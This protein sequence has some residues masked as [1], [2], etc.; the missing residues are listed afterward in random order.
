[1]Q[2]VLIMST[3]A[4]CDLRSEVVG[5]TCEDGDEVKPG[6][7]GNTRAARFAHS[8]ATPLHAIG[9]GWKLIG[10]PLRY[11]EELPTGSTREMMEWWFVRDDA[12][13]QVIP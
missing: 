2:K 13:G 1:M 11:T 3:Y 4:N 12:P 8:Y 5:W 7:I 6:H 9:A 10:P